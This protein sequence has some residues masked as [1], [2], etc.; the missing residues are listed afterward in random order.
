LNEKPKVGTP[1]HFIELVRAALMGIRTG[2]VVGLGSAGQPPRG[3]K[4]AWAQE[5]QDAVE[6]HLESQLLSGA[7]AAGFLVDEPKPTGWPKE[8]RCGWTYTEVTWSGLRFRGFVGAFAAGGKRYAVELRDCLG[9]SSTIGIEKEIAPLRPTATTGKWVHGTSLTGI[10]IASYVPESERPDGMVAT[11]EEK[12][13]VVCTCRGLS[14]D[15]DDLPK[16]L[17]FE[18]HPIHPSPLAPPQDETEHYKLCPLPFGHPGF[19]EA[20][21]F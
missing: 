7:G 5:A 19:C 4:G 11:E 14:R 9:C 1:E 15:P 10:K 18:P 2:R 17:C 16:C 12:A 13:P 21:P 3:E 6:A 20:W 8:C